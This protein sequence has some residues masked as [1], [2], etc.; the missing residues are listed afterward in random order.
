LVYQHAT[1]ERD[2]A[3]ADVLEA[4][5]GAVTRSK[6]APIRALDSAKTEKK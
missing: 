3:V 5:I 6:T 1:E 2:L 4:Q